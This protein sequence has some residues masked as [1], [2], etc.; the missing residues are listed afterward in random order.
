METAQLIPNNFISAVF[1]KYLGER[2]KNDLKNKVNSSHNLFNH[3]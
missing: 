2:V 1:R 3:V